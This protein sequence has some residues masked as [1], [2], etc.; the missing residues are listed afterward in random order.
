MPKVK[1][2]WEK[3][4]RGSKKNLPYYMDRRKIMD[5]ARDFVCGGMS[6]LY[7]NFFED[8]MQDGQ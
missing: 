4:G 5:I 6:Y 2:E 8:Y 3:T 7:D 1:T